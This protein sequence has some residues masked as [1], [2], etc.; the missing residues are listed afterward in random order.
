M[1]RAEL[2]P[3]PGWLYL[4]SYENR[5]GSVNLADFGERS[6]WRCLVLGGTH[7]QGQLT[8][9]AFTKQD[10]RPAH[11]TPQPQHH[12]RRS[13]PLPACAPDRR[14]SDRLARGSDSLV[15]VPSGLDQ[16]TG[17]PQLA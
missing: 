1:S 16:S 10:R 7:D 11:V 5:I 9:G 3:L 13:A 8:L 17:R 12:P 15:R 2:Y 14:T 4:G 6:F